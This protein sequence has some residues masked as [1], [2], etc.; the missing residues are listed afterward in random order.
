MAELDAGLDD[1]SRRHGRRPPRGRRAAKARR[2][3]CD[4][5][6][7]AASGEVGSSAVERMAR[8][9]GRRDLGADDVDAGAAGRP[10]PR[11]PRRPWRAGR[12]RRR[13]LVVERLR[14]ARAP[15]AGVEMEL[16]E[17][18]GG[19]GRDHRLGLAP[20]PLRRSRCR[21]GLGPRWSP[22]RISRDLL[23]RRPRPAMPPRRRPRNPPA[24]CRY[25]RRPG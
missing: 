15:H 2:M 22:P 7:R 12:A 17:A 24:S 4:R 11:R 6:A 8:A 9:A 13:R 14:L 19:I 3:A 25:S 23:E 18:G 1:Q 5:S 16:G 10:A 21:H 20:W